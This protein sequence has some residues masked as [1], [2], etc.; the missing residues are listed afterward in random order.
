MKSLLIVCTLVLSAY[1]APL[2]RWQAARPPVSNGMALAEAPG[3]LW[4]ME[5]RGGVSAARIKPLGD[6]YNRASFLLKV[7]KPI[8]EPAW[9]SIG[10][11]DEGYGL[12]ALNVEGTRRRR[13]AALGERRGIVRLNSGKLRHAV[14]RIEKLDAD[15]RVEGLTLLHSVEI[16]TEEPAREADPPA[17]PAFTLKNPPNLVTTA[18]TDSP[19]PEGL[20]NALAT[21]RT[22]LPLVKALGFNGVESYVKWNFVERSP[23]VFDW[24]YYDAVVDE[25]DRHGL[26]WFPLLIVGSAYSLP[27]WFF[28]SKEF[29]G[30]VCLE[31][32]TKVEIPT[33]FNE[34]QTKYVR[35]FL[36]EF[37]KHYGDRPSL[38]GVRLGPSANYGEAQYPASGNWGY[39]GG[40][41]HTHLGYWAGDPDASVV[42]RGWVKG[43]YPTVKSLNEAWS[44]KYTSF[45]EVKT[46]HPAHAISPRMRID[47]NN[48]YMDSMTEWCERW[49]T[50][51]REAMPHT[52]I[53]QSSGGWG[54]VEIGTD[55]FKQAR[56]MGKLG[57]GI[58]LTNENDSYLNN[59]CVTRPAASSARFY[60]AKIGS[61]PA[62]Y[63][64]AR[65]VMARLYNTIANG[66]DH[67]FYYEG[68]VISNDEAVDAWIR[69]A[70]LLDR[71]VKP[72]IDI[73]VYYP[74][75]SNRLSDEYIRH[76]GA[77][78]F[79]ARAKA[80]RSL[81]DYDFMGEQMILDGALD[82]YKALVFL[83]GNVTERSVIEKIDAWMRNGGTVLFP[84][85][86]Q[87]RREGL[88][89][90]EGDSA[91]WQ[92]WMKGE[93]GKGRLVVFAR[94]SEPL[95]Y[96]MNFLREQ[97]V[98]V[99]GMRATSIRAL[100]LSKPNETYWAVLGNDLLLLN[101]A[102]AAAAVRLNTGKTVRVEPNSIWMNAPGV[103]W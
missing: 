59:W 12:I 28:E 5:Q 55:Y 83:N 90:V 86:P 29:T 35:R 89:T 67:L 98:K 92:R 25:L 42:F 96:Y 31:H 78:S 4:T 56:S 95:D 10:Y 47:F 44:T 68:N 71:R 48:W 103:A 1:A 43:R 45:E 7:A 46:F 3:S 30:Y 70:P 6:Y 20:K 33:I 38:L 39:K 101:Y 65:G 21:M 72:A 37:G 87:A 75:T 85:R 82:R 62:G 32:N 51:A 61:E 53:Y 8:T 66:A 58:R 24:S 19:T 94:Q 54:A 13:G 57:G 84:T 80:F 97:L 69:H 60:G 77:N 36:S 23:G 93:T 79:F 74:D 22:M 14:Y 40:Q 27:E 88:S 52:S 50:W 9:L 16:T 34:N 11:I 73:A 76:L 81:A 102:D 41:I 17:K 99:N 100:K 63:G 2:A 26:K 15:L 64:S 49:A 18:G 91:T